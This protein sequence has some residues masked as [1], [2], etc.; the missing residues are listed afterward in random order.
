MNPRST[1]ISSM[2]AG[3]ALALPLG[4][5]IW[6]GAEHGGRGPVTVLWAMTFGAVVGCV[7]GGGLIVIRLV[8]RRARGASWTMRPDSRPHPPSRN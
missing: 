1:L 7:V 5:L 6:V 3:A 2:V 4:S 8:Y